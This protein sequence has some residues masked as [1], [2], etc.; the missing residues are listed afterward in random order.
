MDI[1]KHQNNSEPSCPDHN[2]TTLKNVARSRLLCDATY[3]IEKLSVANRYTTL[4]VA[5]KISA[6]AAIPAW[7]ALLIRRGCRVRIAAIPPANAYS[8]QTK[9]SNRA[10]E[11]NTSTPPPLS[12]LSAP[13]Y[14]LHGVRCGPVNSTASALRPA[15]LR[16]SKRIS[17]ARAPRRTAR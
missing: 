9:A 14:R 13:T 4:N 16:I 3:D 6:H 2:A 7:R 5:R 12:N 15:L 8:A 1:R 17:P 10:N 11:P